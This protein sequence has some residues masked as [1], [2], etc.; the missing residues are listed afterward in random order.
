M[1]NVILNH[2]Y[3]TYIKDYIMD[4]TSYYY[5]FLILYMK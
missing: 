1:Y 2:L 4:I 5:L 3:I